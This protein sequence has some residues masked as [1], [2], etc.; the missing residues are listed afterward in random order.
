MTVLSKKA[1]H[2]IESGVTLLAD[3]DA[4][5]AWGKWS[6]THPIPKGSFLTQEDDT[7]PPAVLEAAIAALSVKMEELIRCREAA[8]E[9]D[10]YE[11][12]NDLSYAHLIVAS[13]AKAKEAGR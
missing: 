1:R 4:I 3:Q 2:L 13:L 6:A 8:A 5:A 12:E 10:A 11:F 7:F 9:D